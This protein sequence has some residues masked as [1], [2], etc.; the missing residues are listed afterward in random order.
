ARVRPL[1]RDHA[2]LTL[3]RPLPLRVGD[4]VVLRGSDSRLV[5]CGGVVLDVDPPPL[6]RRGDGT[7]RT[8]TLE[9]MP[10]GGDVAAET[11]RRGAIRRAALLRYGIAVPRDLPAGV[12]RHGDWL[13]DA[14]AL[15]HWTTRLRQE[16][17]A[18]RRAHPLSSGPTRK[19][20]A[21]ALELPSPEL[22]D[23]VRA[24]AGLTQEAGRIRDPRATGDLEAAEAGVAIL[25]QR[26]A[27]AP[28]RAPEA[29]DLA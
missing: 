6:T 3:A 25:E 22:L 12:H 24:A 26:L 9:A 28:F 8:R 14:D 1:G 5:H 19:A 21:D 27:G 18:D 10:V 16:V 11:A 15:D 20:A 13:V 29:D 4:R 17:A 7:A 23:V 2:R